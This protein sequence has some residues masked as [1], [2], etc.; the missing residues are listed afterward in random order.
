MLL[1]GL[2]AGSDRSEA[3]QENGDVGTEMAAAVQS[4]WD[5]LAPEKINYA[6]AMFAQPSRVQWGYEPGNR[7][8]LPLF[9]LEPGD[10]ERLWGLLEVAL[11]ADGAERARGVIAAERHIFETTGDESRNPDFY[12][13]E[14][15]GQ[16]GQQGDWAWSFEGHHLS[17]NFTLRDGQVVGST[18]AFF[19]AEPV[20]RSNSAGRGGEAQPLEA[21]AAAGRALL[22]ALD[23][24]QR[25]RAIFATEPPDDILT[26]AD[27]RAFRPSQ[28]GI[29]YADL[30]EPQQALLRELIN[31][32]ASRVAPSMATSEMAAIEAAELDEIRFGWAGPITPGSAHYYRVQAPE[33][34]IEYGHV[35]GDPDHEHS[36]WRKFDDD[37]GRSM[38]RASQPAAVTTLGQATA[39]AP[40]TSEETAAAAA[41]AQRKFE[42]VEGIVEPNRC[43]ALDLVTDR[44][45]LRNDDPLPRGFDRA[46]DLDVV[47][48]EILESSPFDGLANLCEIGQTIAAISPRYPARLIGETI[49]V[50]LAL[51][52]DNRSHAWQ[53]SRIQLQR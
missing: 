53:A 5:G 19:G 9:A 18:P 44:R 37:F 34:L 27:S 24:G 23:A 50:G 6:T 3:A 21:E 10:R 15:F 52:G 16:H 17:I 4:L 11:G 42:L 1:V 49:S 43:R 13:L 12:L 35:A 22:E 31:T 20:R 36:G 38:L 47:T 14:V 32:Y 40:A 30:T 7:S 25:R 46:P 41:S 48:V 39:P 29:R 51:A 2:F 26:G 8:G 45:P 28:L 33:F